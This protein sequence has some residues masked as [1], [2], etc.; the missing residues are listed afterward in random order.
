[1]K[2]LSWAEAIE[3]IHELASAVGVGRV[4]IRLSQFRELC[5]AVEIFVA[6]QGRRRLTTGQRQQLVRIR[7]IR[8]IEDAIAEG[9][10]PRLDIHTPRDW[11]LGRSLH[12]MNE[13]VRFT[14]KV[15]HRLAFT[16][17]V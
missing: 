5:D 16:G 15:R 12:E 17:G 7:Y 10:D 2:R 8:I 3:K 4:F 1:M 13:A 14:W 11:M 6:R 9:H